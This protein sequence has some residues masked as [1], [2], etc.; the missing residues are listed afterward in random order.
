MA[1]E[2]TRE[3]EL[4]LKTDF[5]GDFLDREIGCFKQFTG[6]MYF[7]AREIAYRREIGLAPKDQ[8]EMSLGPARRLAQS[9]SVIGRD[10]FSRM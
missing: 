1:A 9:F 7:K 6:S 4:I 8:T 10:R 3:I 5:S 2:Q